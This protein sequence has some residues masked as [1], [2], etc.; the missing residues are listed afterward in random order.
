ME[1]PL[2]RIRVAHDIDKWRTAVDRVMK[3]NGIACLAEDLGT[4]CRCKCM[5]WLVCTVSAYNSVCV[6][7]CVYLCV[8]VF[9]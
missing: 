8:Y 2:R 4:R 1:V 7:V 3:L 6:C 9:M 5:C